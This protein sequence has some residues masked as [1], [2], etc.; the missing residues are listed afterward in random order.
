[1]VIKYQET[2]KKGILK[3]YPEYNVAL[4]DTLNN[5][6][7]EYL[8]TVNGEII[9]NGQEG[10]IYLELGRKNN[11]LCSKIFRHNDYFL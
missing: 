5:I 4:D 8:K 10:T 9:E 7:E 11:V 2:L 1:M 6:I 3:D